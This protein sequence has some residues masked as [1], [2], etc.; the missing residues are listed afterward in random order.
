MKTRE[1]CINY[2]LDYV[3]K[4][5]YM[6]SEEYNRSIALNIV[7]HSFN[8]NEKIV[9]ESGIMHLSFDILDVNAI[10]NYLETRGL[11][12]DNLKLY[13]NT[14]AFVYLRPLLSFVNTRLI[15]IEY[16]D[17]IGNNEII[18]INDYLTYDYIASKALIP[19]LDGLKYCSVHLMN[20]KKVNYLKEILEIYPNHN[21]NDLYIKLEFRNYTNIMYSF[22]SL[23][24]YKV[25]L[26]D[27]SKYYKGLY[28][29]FDNKDIEFLKKCS[30]NVV[31][32]LIFYI[33]DKNLGI[34]FSDDVSDENCIFMNGF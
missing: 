26:V 28:I 3:I 14:D 11:Y 29:Y 4:D 9:N 19:I 17:I 34:V 23:S 1:E 18:D 6:N 2:I 12:I 22:D 7:T 21:F 20:I 25:D 10:K 27:I 30:Y 33:K 13:V 5:Y 15:N 32:G 8:T 16:L 31:S 24:K